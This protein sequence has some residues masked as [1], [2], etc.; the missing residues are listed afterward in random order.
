MRNIVCKDDAG[1]SLIAVLGFLLLVSSILAP[2]SLVSHNRLVTT[3]YEFDLLKVEMISHTIKQ[4]LASQISSESLQQDRNESGSLHSFGC[5]YGDLK[6]HINV[7]TF[8]G[9]VDLNTANLELLTIA[10]RAL[11]FQQSD[12]LANA[13]IAYRSRTQRD[14]IDSDIEPDGGLKNSLF[15]SVVE[16]H[17]FKALRKFSKFELEDIFTVYKK[18]ALVSLDNADPDLQRELRA[19]QL[20]NQNIAFVENSTRS[21]RGFYISTFVQMPNRGWHVDRGHYILQNTNNGA[22]FVLVESTNSD[23]LQSEDKAFLLTH[24]HRAE[25]CKSYAFQSL[26]E[27]QL[28]KS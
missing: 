20:E 27:R 26:F 5:T 9:L 12:E 17:D 10:F 13:I 21:R 11:G 25:L 23:V 7:K 22:S 15:E 16:L 28:D 2:L 4:V 14:I 24:T 8:A 18:S 19:A 6:F 3:K 1:F